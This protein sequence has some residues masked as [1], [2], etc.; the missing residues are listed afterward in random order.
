MSSVNVN[1]SP[2]WKQYIDDK[3]HSG[4][5][6][7]VSEIVREALRLMEEREQI[8]AAKLLDLR[9]AIDEGDTSGDPVPLDIHRIIA[10]AK[11]ERQPQ[12]KVS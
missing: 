4:R 5:Y 8:R 7:N 9:A 11:A 12:H 10:E 2:Y 6:N 3:L 1:L